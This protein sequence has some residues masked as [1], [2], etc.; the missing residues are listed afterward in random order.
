MKMIS[1]KNDPIE[2]KI[3]EEDEDA[4]ELLAKGKKGDITIY[5]NLFKEDNRL[6]LRNVHLDGMGSGYSSLTELR[7]I[8]REF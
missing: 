6:I 2:L 1:K 5:A 7:Q 8:A 4:I 3:V